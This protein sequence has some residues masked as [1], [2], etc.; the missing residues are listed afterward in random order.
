MCG[1][2]LDVALNRLPAGW[3]QLVLP[4]P[5]YPIQFVGWGRRWGKS[6]YTFDEAR[7]EFDEHYARVH[8]VFDGTEYHGN[9]EPDDRPIDEVVYDHF[10]ARFERSDHAP[11]VNHRLYGFRTAL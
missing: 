9:F 5:Q 8:D 2:V 10:R 6:R 3:S 11:E 1:E 4:D 7:R